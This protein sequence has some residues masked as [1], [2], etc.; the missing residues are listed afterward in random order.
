MIGRCFWCFFWKV[1]NR[2]KICW[3]HI[4]W[5][6]WLIIIIIT[7][8]VINHSQSLSHDIWTPTQV[9][10]EQLHLALRICEPFLA[11]MNS[12]LAWHILFPWILV[13]GYFSDYRFFLITQWQFWLVF[14][15]FSIFSQILCPLMLLRKYYFSFFGQ[16][17]VSELALLITRCCQWWCSF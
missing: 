2:Q 11:C 1:D 4:K 8:I 12:V 16:R 17:F 15:L 5:I 13:H 10:S 14:C 3:K 9:N 6:I 7:I